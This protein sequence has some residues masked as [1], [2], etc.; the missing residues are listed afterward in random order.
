MSAMRVRL[1]AVFHMKCIV[2]MQRFSIFEI[3]AEN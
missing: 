3:K 2:L 1:P